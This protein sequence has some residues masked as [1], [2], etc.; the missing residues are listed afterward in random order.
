MEQKID[1]VGI[2]CD[3]VSHFSAAAQKALIEAALIYAS[4]EQ[5]LIV[6]R[7]FPA[8]KAQ[9]EP[10]PKPISK[11]SST[12][13]DHASKKIVMMALGDPLFYGIGAILLRFLPADRLHFHPAISSLQAAL[14]RFGLPWNDLAVVS[15]HGCSLESLPRLLK[16]KGRYG[17]LTDT[18][19]SP[20]RIALELLKM[21]QGAAV[22]R[23]AESLGR[24]DEKCSTYNAEGL[25]MAKKPFSPLLVLVI[26]IA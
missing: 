6:K 25:A 5:Q 20:Q 7:Y 9:F 8:L 13:P 21:G 22:V 18:K 1:V 4:I 15:L 16:D 10:Y 23:V 17:I 11:L 12:L 3:D 26:D 14:S 24:T 2:S 19:N